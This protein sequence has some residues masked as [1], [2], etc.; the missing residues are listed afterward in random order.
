MTAQSMPIT[1]WLIKMSMIV[2]ERIAELER[3]KNSPSATIE[4]K[5]TAK[6]M[7]VINNRWK[8]AIDIAQKGQSRLGRLMGVQ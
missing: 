4:E 8:D 7:L 2:N 3:K 5:K 1:E 6:D